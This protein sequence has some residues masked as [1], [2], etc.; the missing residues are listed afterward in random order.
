MKEKVFLTA[1]WRKL[2]MANYVIDPSVLVPYMPAG[3]EPDHW[4]G[5]CYVSLV[6]FMF[7]NVRVKGISIPFHTDF[8]EV[9]LRFYVRYQEKNEWKRGVV[10]ISEIVPKPAIS[11]VANV[12]FNEHY[13]AMPMRHSC[14]AKDEKLNASYLWK[15]KGKWNHLEV[16]ADAKPE[17]LQEGSMEEFITEHFWG[18]SAI[19]Q[20][21]TGEYHVEH[22]RW[23]IYPVRS[24]TIECD[25]A[26]L[27]GDD[28]AFLQQAKPV[29][30]FMAE[31][32]A[33]KVFTKK[34]LSVSF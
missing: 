24:Y 8:P 19:G 4:N 29:S 2:I 11:F 20:H 22:P 25:F 14:Q 32:S 17:A 5:H 6:G 26:A 28:F 10:F 30:V 3:I 13:T 23:D 1:E 31:G 12:L 9:N 33:V 16:L 27:Y 34:V 18:Y 15:T 21:K 7:N